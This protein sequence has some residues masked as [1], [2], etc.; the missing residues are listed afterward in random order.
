MHRLLPMY[1]NSRYRWSMLAMHPEVGPAYIR[2]KLI[3]GGN[4]AKSI[5]TQL[6]S[7]PRLRWRLR[8]LHRNR[9]CRP[10]CS[11]TCCEPLRLGR[12]HFIGGGRNHRGRRARPG[13]IL[14]DHHRTNTVQIAGWLLPTVRAVSSQKTSDS[15]LAETEFVLGWPPLRCETGKGPKVTLPPVLPTRKRNSACLVHYHV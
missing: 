8:S 5:A 10:G 6:L 3:S 7:R 4:I 1:R 9:H 2:L 12:Q 14:G 11:R 13:R 15:L